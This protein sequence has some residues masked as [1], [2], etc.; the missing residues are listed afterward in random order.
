ME[1][2]ACIPGLRYACLCQSG[3]EQSAALCS[4]E[5]HL[6]PNPEWA[7]CRFFTQRACGADWRLR[8]CYQKAC[9]ERPVAAMS[10]AKE[11]IKSSRGPPVTSRFFSVLS[12]TEQASKDGHEYLKCFNVL[13]P[14]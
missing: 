13:N 5:F 8:H 14:T 2:S 4:R 11:S 6:E 9:P 10:Q 3:S 1:I 12:L 7:P